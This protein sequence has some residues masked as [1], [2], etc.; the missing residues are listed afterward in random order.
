VDVL[1]CPFFITL[2]LKWVKKEEINYYFLFES[3][4]YIPLSTLGLFRINGYLNHQTFLK[5]I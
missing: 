2:S 1:F 3:I 4:K 5:N